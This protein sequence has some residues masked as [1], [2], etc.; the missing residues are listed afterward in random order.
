VFSITDRFARATDVI[1]TD[2]LPVLGARASVHGA[3]A[4]EGVLG[5]R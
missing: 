3:E 1:N 5:A 4:F 2:F